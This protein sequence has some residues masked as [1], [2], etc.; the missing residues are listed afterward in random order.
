MGLY[1]ARAEVSFIFTLPP[2]PDSVPKLQASPAAQEHQ[3]EHWRKDTPVMT[4]GAVPHAGSAKNEENG[5]REKCIAQG[6][7]ET[8]AQEKI[9]AAGNAC[10]SYN[11][12]AKN[13]EK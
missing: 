4:H 12:H 11:R 6:A 10:G 2:E 9:N 7:P 13:S 8:N 3:G 1:I 5:N